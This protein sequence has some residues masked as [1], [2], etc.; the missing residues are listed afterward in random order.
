[1]LVR[2]TAAVGLWV[3]LV[4]SALDLSTSLVPAAIDAGHPMLSRSS[5]GWFI[6]IAMLVPLAWLVAKRV[7]RVA[8]WLRALPVPR[9]AKYALAVVCVIE[10]A[11]VALRA[12]SYPFTPVA[13][14]STSVR[15]SAEAVWR[16]RVYVVPDRHGRPVVLDFLREGSP[17]FAR[18]LDVDYKT[19]WV[20]QLHAGGSRRGYAFVTHAL[21]QHGMT[22]PVVAD[23][24][25]SV[26]DGSLLSVRRVYP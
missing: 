26:R 22:Y 17:W 16:D 24:V 18:W 7:P 14:F 20:L 21:A 5:V 11:H 4:A 6:Q 12:E 9:A 13:M 1:P 2:M 23:V 10:C 3:A 15:P 19:G 8:Q 25:W